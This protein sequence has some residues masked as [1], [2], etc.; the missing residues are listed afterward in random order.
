MAADHAALCSINQRHQQVCHGKS[1]LGYIV[2]W[3]AF[4]LLTNY[5]PSWLNQEM[6]LRGRIPLGIGCDLSDNRILGKR[7]SQHDFEKGK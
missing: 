5:L 2:P 4:S 1:G 3:V 7:V 6:A